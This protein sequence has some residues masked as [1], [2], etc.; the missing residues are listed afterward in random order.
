MFFKLKK[1]KVVKITLAR[2]VFSCDIK[3]VKPPPVASYHYL[4][5][6]SSYRSAPDYPHPIT[7]YQLKQQP[8]NVF[9]IRVLSK[10]YVKCVPLSS[11]VEVSVY[12]SFFSLWRR[13]NRRVV[14]CFMRSSSS[15]RTQLVIL[16]ILVRL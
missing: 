3:S 15:S 14:F 4:K 8:Q 1:Q 6:L 13:C 12:Y 10:S 9:I 16:C 11:C 7:V 2:N 5:Q